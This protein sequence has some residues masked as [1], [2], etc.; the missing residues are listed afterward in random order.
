M[1]LIKCRTLFNEMKLV[2]A[3]KMVQRPSVYGVILQDRKL[4]VAKARYTQKYVLPGGGIDPGE[5]MI[6]ALM[7]E[8]KEETG[9]EV[10]VG[11]FL[12]FQTDFFYYD[13]L[14]LAIHGFL[15]YYRCEPMSLE[16]NQPNY[17]PEDELELALWINIDDLNPDSFQ[18]HGQLTID[19]IERLER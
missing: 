17:P 18:T 10:E 14:D 7:R 9:I 8:V 12:Q 2:P 1:A 4:L 16:I 11:E 6:A 15:F 19:L 13:P 3:E 5:E